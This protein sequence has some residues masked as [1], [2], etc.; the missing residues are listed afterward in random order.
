MKKYTYI[1][2]IF[3]VMSATDEIY[4][5]RLFM[6]NITASPRP[7]LIVA[8]NAP[9]KLLMEFYGT[10]ENGGYK[11]G[12]HLVLNSLKLYEALDYDA[13]DFVWKILERLIYMPSK[14]TVVLWSFEEIF[15]SVGLSNICKSSNSYYKNLLRNR[16]LLL[17]LLP[18]AK[19]LDHVRQLIP[20]NI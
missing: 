17:L 16:D 14:E 3:E 6:D 7:I 13:R 8:S 2:L 10:E 9:T 1:A 18:G 15:E 20:E 11:N 5:W 19:V 12:A 4:Q